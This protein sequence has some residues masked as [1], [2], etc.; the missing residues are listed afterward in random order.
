MITLTPLEKELLVKGL[1]G[2]I[3]SI[4]AI[5][6]S[7]IQKGLFESLTSGVTITQLGIAEANVVLAELTPSEET[8]SEVC[9][10]I[11]LEITQPLFQKPP[12]VFRESFRQKEP[13]RAMALV[14]AFRIARARYQDSQMKSVSVDFAK[15]PEEL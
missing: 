14:G 3:K 7:L 10:V 8:D 5:I 15:P 12:I 9:W 4:P 2:P 13:N 1:S 6:G 11:T